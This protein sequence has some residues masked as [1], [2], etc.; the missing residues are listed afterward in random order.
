MSFAV[1]YCFCFWGI[2][3]YYISYFY[4]GG[5][6]GNWVLRIVLPIKK[7]ATCR[8]AVVLVVPALAQIRLAQ[9]NIYLLGTF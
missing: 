6:H 3:Y 2:C 8:L 5:M 1:I 9:D 7:L 4:S